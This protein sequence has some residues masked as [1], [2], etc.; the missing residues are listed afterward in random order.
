MT[1]WNQADPPETL[2]LW[3]NTDPLT[4]FQATMLALGRDPALTCTGRPKAYGAMEQ[5]LRQT[6]GRGEILALVARPSDGYP[7]TDYE[8]ATYVRQ[9]D[10]R[11]WLRRI[12]YPGAYFFLD[13][14]KGWPGTAAPVPE[15]AAPGAEDVGLKARERNNLLRV[16]RALDAMNPQPLPANG[17]CDSITTQVKALGLR[18]PDD[19]TIRKI[20]EAARALKA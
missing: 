5:A 4:L 2:R 16:V 19:D 7:A 3:L 15:A 13:D 18:A 20:I 12:G 11:G 8:H 6:I 17:Y 14:P 9:V 1:D 10:V